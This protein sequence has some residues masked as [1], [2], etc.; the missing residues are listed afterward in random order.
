MLGTSM[1]ETVTLVF[2]CNFTYTACCWGTLHEQSLILRYF[3]SLNV[4]ALGKIFKC[5]KE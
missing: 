2:G 5:L 1:K 4:T 3:G